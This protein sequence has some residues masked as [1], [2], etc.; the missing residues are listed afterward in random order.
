MALKLTWNQFSPLS[1]CLSCKQLQNASSNAMIFYLWFYSCIRHTLIRRQSSNI[2]TGQG[3]CCQWWG[4]C[5]MF[6]PFFPLLFSLVGRQEPCNQRSM[7]TTSLLQIC[8]ATIPPVQYWYFC[9]TC[10]TN[11]SARVCKD[12]LRIPRSRECQN[13]TRSSCC[14]WSASYTYVILIFWDVN[15]LIK[16]QNITPCS[17]VFWA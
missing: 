10:W 1:T 3:N 13:C 14:D 6:I 15:D 17:I 4:M 11:C 9:R 8:H 5:L 7:L 16:L 2:S 12:V